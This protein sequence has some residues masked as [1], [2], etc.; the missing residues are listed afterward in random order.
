MKWFTAKIVFGIHHSS[1]EAITQYD[2]QI[3]MIQARDEH[4][5]FLKS[6]MLGVREE[7]SFVNENEEEVRW[8][9][10]DVTDLSEISELKDGMELYSRIH[11]IDP[12]EQYIRFVH[13]KALQLSHRMDQLEIPH[14]VVIS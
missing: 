6:R 14:A 11:E 13:D 12:R 2:E 5:A 7:Y 8:E 10:V 9:F 1:Q 4:E 3:R